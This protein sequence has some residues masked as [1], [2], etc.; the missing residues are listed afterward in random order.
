M[1]HDHHH[2]PVHHHPAHHHAVHAPF[3]PGRSL[4]RMGLGERL[5][6]AG[7]ISAGLWLAITWALA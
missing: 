2:H 5:A 1:A 6:I 3:R 4:F 7:V